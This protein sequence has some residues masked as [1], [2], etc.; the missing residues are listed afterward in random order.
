MYRR[1]MPSARPKK[2]ATAE[3]R[4]PQLSVHLPA[5]LGAQESSIDSDPERFY[6]APYVGS[7][8]WIGVVLDAKT[9]W[10]MVGALVETA[11][12]VIAS[13]DAR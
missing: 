10:K 6:R 7:K 4:A 9:D 12:G 8:G 5:P 11:Y 3:K 2:K 1:G 13:H